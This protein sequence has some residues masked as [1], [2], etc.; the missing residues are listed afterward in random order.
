[1]FC[2]TLAEN[3]CKKLFKK[4]ER[5]A[6]YTDFFEIRADKLK[7]LETCHLETFLKLPYKFLFTFRSHEEGGFGNFSDEF[8]LEWIFWALKQ[9]FYLVDIEWKLFKKFSHKFK[10]LN[11]N[12]VLFSYHNFK[13][14]PSDRY[15]LEL[16]S[17][18]KKR[19]VKRAK[20]VCMCNS[21]EDSFRLLKLIFLAK[22][23]KIE[24][25]AF[26]MGEKGRI[27]RI[28]SLFCG[29]PF[30]YVVLSKKEAVA[31]GQLDIK[32]ALKVY[33]AIK[34]IVE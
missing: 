22:E 7:D 2:L 31:P 33:N 8:R 25:V 34:E 26:G 3:T 1:M 9:K 24:L 28:L 5:G 20:I 23:R 18:M 27:S 21:L 15:L 30:T 12:K 32:S 19:G 10:E 16:L 14:L 29:S 6:K 4:I 17:E 11:F 13:K